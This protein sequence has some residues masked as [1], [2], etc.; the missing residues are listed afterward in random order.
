MSKK[1]F[2][3]NAVQWEIS[4]FLHLLNPW[5]QGNKGRILPKTRRWLFDLLRSRLSGNLAPIVVLRGPRQ[6]GKTVLQ[7]QLIMDLLDG[8]IEPNRIFHVQFD[9]VDERGLMEGLPL[10]ST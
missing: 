8:G 1:L 10:R 2:G 3:N 4:N 5:W 9:D 6:V 7:Q